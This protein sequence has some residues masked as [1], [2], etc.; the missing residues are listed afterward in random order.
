MITRYSYTMRDCGI[1]P[2]TVQP[3]TPESV[4]SSTWNPIKMVH[5]VRAC[6]YRY[7]QRC[8]LPVDSFPTTRFTNY[9]YLPLLSLLFIN[10][11]LVYY[12]PLLSPDQV[13]R[14]VCLES[15]AK[16][17]HRI[18]ID[19]IDGQGS[20]AHRRGAKGE[21]SRCCNPKRQ[22]GAPQF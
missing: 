4:T 1:N 13:P 15:G 12:V 22:P 2:R 11:S 14:S 20:A 17:W 10:I 9:R 6:N 5:W 8:T 3:A 7:A 19:S 21:G 18:A 16:S